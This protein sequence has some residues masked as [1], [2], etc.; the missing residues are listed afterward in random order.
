MSSRRAGEV[1]VAVHLQNPA[2]D[3]AS[4]TGRSACAIFFASVLIE[5]DQR[6]WG[7]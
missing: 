3:A 2:S 1:V 5:L 7:I 4:L 6:F